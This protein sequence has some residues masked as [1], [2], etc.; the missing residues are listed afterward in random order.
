MNM[1]IGP[2]HSTTAATP[3]QPSYCTL[4]MF[5]PPKSVNDPVNGPGYI[6]N[7]GHMF[8]CRSPVGMQQAFHV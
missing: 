4:P 3:G 8:E 6:S 1:N 5:H 2:E 7:D